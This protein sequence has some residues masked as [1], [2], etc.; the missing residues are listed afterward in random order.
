MIVVSV[1]IGLLGIFVGCSLY[2][3]P[4]TFIKDVDFAGAGTRYLANMWGARQIT[5]AAILGFAALRKS[6]PMLQLSLG[7][8][9]L[10]NVQDAVIGVVRGDMGLI[11]GATLFALGP[12]YMVFRL[13]RLNEHLGS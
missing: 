8:Y 2:V 11:V 1:L 10:M 6:V 4:G 5:L 13:T 12:A 3:S 7:A 9:A